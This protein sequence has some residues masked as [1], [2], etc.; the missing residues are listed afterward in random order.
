[1][2]IKI[3]PDDSARYI[4]DYEEAASTWFL[5]R[6][7]VVVGKGKT[8]IEAVINWILNSEVVSVEIVHNANR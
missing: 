1:M 3:D 6:D 2:R 5:E 4:F 7:Q 8:K